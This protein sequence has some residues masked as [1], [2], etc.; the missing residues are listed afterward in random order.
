MKSKLSVEVQLL[1]DI[2][3][4]LAD[5]LDLEMTLRSLLKSLDTH[6]KPTA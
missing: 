1:S 4:A 2:S 6:L 5:S 3:K